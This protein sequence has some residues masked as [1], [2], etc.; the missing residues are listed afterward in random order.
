MLPG[1]VNSRRVADTAIELL[2]QDNSQIAYVISHDSSASAAS[3]THQ[4][5]A[6]DLN[7]EAALLMGEAKPYKTRYQ[8]FDLFLTDTWALEV[9]WCIVA[10]AFL[11]GMSAFLAANQ[12]VPQPQWPYGISINTVVSLLVGAIG[13]ALASVLSACIG[14]T[15][16]QWFASPRVLSDIEIFDR[17]T[18]DLWGK[19]RVKTSRAE[20]LN[21]LV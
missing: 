5:R 13:G 9:F 21:L 6:V 16:W 11:A 14:Q 19:L 2:F 4:E 18:R 20:S 10:I 7:Q 15:K 8:R 3:A 1:R 17:A 12:G